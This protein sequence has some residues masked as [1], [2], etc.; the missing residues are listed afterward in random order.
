M[1]KE[2]IKQQN[3]KGFDEGGVDIFLNHKMQF[4]GFSN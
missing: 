4:N 1:A 3:Q 2:N